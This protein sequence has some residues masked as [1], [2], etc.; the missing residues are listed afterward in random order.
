MFFTSINKLFFI[1]ILS[2]SMLLPCFGGDESERW[3]WPLGDSSGDV[4]MKPGRILNPVYGNLF[5]NYDY[6][7]AGTSGQP[8]YSPVEGYISSTSPYKL[9][10]PDAT[11]E[12]SF[13]SID[14]FN[15]MKE[16]ST[17]VFFK[18]DNLTKTIYIVS[19]LNTQPVFIS[20]FSTIAVR[21]GQR[22]RKGEYIGDMGYIR[23]FSTR[24][25]IQISSPHVGLF[26]LGED[27]SAV[28][29]SLPKAV[30]F[31]PKT[32]VSLPVMH[33]AV[34]I[35]STSIL[36]DHPA[37]L[38]TFVMDSFK[39]AGQDLNASLYENMP[40]VD[41]LY[42]LR[43]AVAQL[44]C[45]HTA[46]QAKGSGIYMLE[47]PLNLVIHDNKAYVINDRRG[48]LDIPVGTRVLAINGHSVQNLLDKQTAVISA[49]SRSDQVRREIAS[50]QIGRIVSLLKFPAVYEYRLLMND[51]SERIVSIPRLTPEQI[52]DDTLFPEWYNI[53]PASY[54]V[55]N[56]STAI[57]R[58]NEIDQVA[59]Q[60]LVTGWFRD[61]A[62]KNITNLI[63]DLRGNGGGDIKNST[64]FFS[65]LAKQ[66]FR[67]EAYSEIR[68]SGPYESLRYSLN[69]IDSQT[70]SYPVEFSDY[71]TLTDGRYIKRGG[72]EIGR[73]I[74]FHFNG[75]VYVLVDSGTASAAVWLSR[76]LAEQGAITVGSE[77]GGGFYEC[78]AV[79]SNCIRLGETGLELY[80]PLIH[81]VFS[82][83]MDSLQV[84]PDRGLM[85]RFPVN[86]S[87]ED[88]LYGT[89]SVLDYTLNLVANPPVKESPI[90]NNKNLILFL[91]AGVFLLVIVTVILILLRKKR[92]LDEK[93]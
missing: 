92:I 90:S 18:E 9:L 53:E 77:T 4:I 82:D 73:A 6:Y 71:Q 75:S 48:N 16:Q 79:K 35:F 32:I 20:G 91:V 52:N 46:I 68:H 64:F 84:P 26:L 15:E 49:D 54:E 43:L 27:N 7:I 89:D 45:T 13:S 31:N 5:N 59:D 56:P 86:A 2:V 58:L 29:A 42:Q 57:I 80:M 85:P 14:D 60:E 51:G 41:F 33:E 21:E 61:L 25:C 40:A 37:L 30:T 23:T 34:D 22:V 72:E 87:L 65:Y 38:D 83:N 88:K 76:F 8:I 78:N 28:F 12:W 19:S 10:A 36:N 47:W 69:M 39:K 17:N 24:P 11:Y 66:S 74:E 62:E 67:E 63:V 93:I 55:L 3:F 81:T 50:T 1:M 44:H 70:E